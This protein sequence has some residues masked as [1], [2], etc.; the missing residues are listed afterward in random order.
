MGGQLY[1]CCCRLSMRKGFV[2]GY[3]SDMFVSE[4]AAQEDYG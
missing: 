1:H 4:A 2:G 3:L